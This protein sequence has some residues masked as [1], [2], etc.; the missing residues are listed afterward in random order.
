MRE[1]L[2]RR[3]Q[4]ESLESMTLLSGSA[5][6]VGG[7]I[8]ALVAPPAPTSGHMIRL[9]GTA[10]GRF[11]AHINNP[12]TGKDFTFF[13]SGQVAP[14]GHVDLTGHIHSPGFIANGHSTGLLVLSNPKGSVTLSLIGPVQSGFTPVPDTFTFKITNASGKFKGDTGTG[15]MVLELEPAAA[16]TLTGEHGSFTMIFLT[17][18]PPTAGRPAATV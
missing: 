11:H 14:L 2:R 8:A 5:A 9:T 6:A 18:A 17:V 13:G 7:A 1:H 10:K 3:P 12:D 4:L 15:F 16:P